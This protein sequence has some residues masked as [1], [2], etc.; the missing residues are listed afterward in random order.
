MSMSV[1]AVYNL[2]WPTNKLLTKWCLYTNVEI[3]VSACTRSDVMHD[4]VLVEAFDVHFAISKTNIAHIK[5]ES[6]ACAVCP[7]E[8]FDDS[9]VRIYQQCAAGT[10]RV[11]FPTLQALDTWNDVVYPLWLSVEDKA[12]AMRNVEEEEEEDNGMIHCNNGQMC[13]FGRNFPRSDAAP[14]S[15]ER[16]HFE[17]TWTCTQCIIFPL[18]LALKET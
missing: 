14:F 17:D 8:Y 3:L 13:P 16:V 10:Y 11:Q 12:S 7:L 15:P 18:A 2:W 9:L 4:R 5:F 6:G 1:S